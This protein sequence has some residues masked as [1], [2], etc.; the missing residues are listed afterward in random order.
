MTFIAPQ[1]GSGF[2]AGKPDRLCRRIA[3]FGGRFADDGEFHREREA[4]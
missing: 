3:A 2:A 1:A 4:F